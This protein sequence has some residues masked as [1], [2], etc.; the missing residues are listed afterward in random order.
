MAALDLGGERLLWGFGDLVL[1]GVLSLF[2]GLLL[3]FDL[4]S[5][6]MAL[7]MGVPD[8]LRIVLGLTLEW[9]WTH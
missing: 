4:L 8:L 9:L 3:S 7:S 1:D 2:F 6:L 5:M